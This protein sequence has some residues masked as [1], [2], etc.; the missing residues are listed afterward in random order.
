MNKNI[1]C[2]ISIPYLIVFEKYLIRRYII[3]MNTVKV[4]SVSSV[5]FISWHWYKVK[6]KVH[7]FLARKLLMFIDQYQWSLVRPIR[8]K[9]KWNWDYIKIM[10]QLFQKIRWYFTS[11]LISSVTYTKNT[12]ISMKKNKGRRKGNK[13]LYK[14]IYE[15]KETN[16]PKGIEYANWMAI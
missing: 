15:A 11:V 8:I 14:I 3:Q 1:R 12:E 10:Y 16:R 2:K 4:K 13:L 5:L 7:L 6:K 9:T